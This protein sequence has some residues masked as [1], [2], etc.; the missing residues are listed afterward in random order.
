[1][2][3][4]DRWLL[5]EGVDEALPRQARR[6]ERERRR[7]LDLYESWGYELVMPPFIEFLDSLLTG[8]GSDLEIETFK[9]TD[10]MSGR[11]MGVRADMTPQVA[12][13]DAH[14]L[15]GDGPRRLCYIGTVL[16]TRTD[17]LGGSRSPLQ[18]G[19]EI[20]GHAGLDSDLEVILLML[21]SLRRVSVAPVHLDLGHVGIYRAIAA[22]AGL[23]ATEE[24]QLFA[25]MQR[26]SLPGIK[27]FLDERPIAGL[28]GEMLFDLAQMHGGSAVLKRAK[29]LYAA[30]LPEIEAHLDHLDAV[31]QALREHEPDIELHF[32]LAE[33]RGYHYKTGVVFA[34]FLPGQGQ[35]IARGGRYD[36]IGKVFGRARPAT[37]F[38]MD[39]KR[40]IALAADA[41]EPRDSGV[42]VRNAYKTKAAEAIAAL[43]SSGERVILGLGDSARSAGCDRELV[44]D[45]AAWKLVTLGAS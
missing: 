41:P 11:M 24:V 28:W 6:L 23:T 12:R 4:H 37:G 13:I 17:G 43:R 20:F 36:E 45:G 27:S 1:M 16:R 38:S 14:R 40:L 34:A 5:P 25:L 3:T 44:P 39:L 42:Y 26:K 35:E 21:E 7:L 31:A 18:V 10:Q 8:A 33:L 19:A 9:L 32:D 2:S 22:A 29:D 15:P 30:K